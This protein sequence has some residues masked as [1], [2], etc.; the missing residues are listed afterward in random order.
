M[1]RG[2]CC[3]RVG[4]LLE[5]NIV[6]LGREVIVG[7]YCSAAVTLDHISVTVMCLISREENLWNVS[8][9]QRVYLSSLV[10]H[11]LNHVKFFTFLMY[12]PY[13]NQL[14]IIYVT[15]YFRKEGIHAWVL[16]PPHLQ[17]KKTVYFPHK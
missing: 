4:T 5:H 14:L 6:T 13:Q 1:T 2:N 8:A 17:E 11:V 12:I 9:C 7:T 15:L 10:I 3:R 16:D